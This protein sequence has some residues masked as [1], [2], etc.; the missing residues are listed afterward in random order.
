AALAKAN[1]E[2]PTSA[3]NG[4]NMPDWLTH[5]QFSSPEFDRVAFSL[6]P[7]QTSDLVKVDYG[8][9]IVQVLQKEDGR[10]KP[11]EEVR[12]DLVSQIQKERANDMMQ[13]ISDK[14]QSELQKDPAHPEKVASELNMEL[15]QANNVEPNQPIPGIGANPDLD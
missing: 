14:A 13:K 15:M 5:G 6:K 10:L 3:A 11:F 9:H 1:S 2:D 4:G 7:G 8:Y 12:G